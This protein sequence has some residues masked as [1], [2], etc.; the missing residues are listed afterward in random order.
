MGTMTCLHQDDFEKFPDCGVV[1]HDQ[2]QSGAVDAFWCRLT[3]GRVVV[4]TILRVTF[5]RR[6]RY[7]D[8]EHRALAA[9]RFDPDGVVQQRA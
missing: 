7:L 9:A 3:G 5:F 1:L 2:D 6:K 8:G 4:P